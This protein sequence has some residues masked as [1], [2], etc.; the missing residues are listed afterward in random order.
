[1]GY[2]WAADY[3]RTYLMPPALDDWIGP[4]HPARFVR[5]FVERF[6][7]KEWQI[8]ERRGGFGRPAYEEELL[9]KLWMYAY[10]R[11]I[12]SSRGVERA[13][14]EMVPFMWLAGEHR[15]DHNTLWRFWTGHQRTIGRVFELGLDVSREMELVGLELQAVDGTKIQACG[16]PR[17]MTTREQLERRRER[18]HQRRLE[19]ERAI[20]QAEEREKNEPEVGGLTEELQNRKRLEEKIDELLEKI[21]PKARQNP[22]EKDARPLK[23]CG[24]GYNAQAMVDDTAGLIVAEAVVSDANDQKQLVPMVDQVVERFGQPAAETLAD[25]GYNTERALAEAEEKNYEVLVAAGPG[26]PTRDDQKPYHSTRFTHDPIRDVVV[27]PA[28]K[29]LT[30]ERTKRRKNGTEVRIFRGRECRDCPVRAACTRD[31][32]GRSFDLSPHRGAVMRQR[33]KRG[34]PTNRQRYKR[35][36]PLAERTFAVIKRQLRFTRFKARG[37]ANA[38]LEWNFICGI[39]NLKLLAALPLPA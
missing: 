10:L 27:C 6:S 17:S 26:E 35:R 38:A 34:L 32:R 7:S 23:G 16:S 4:D 15:P 28:G 18:N 21:D 8:E 2:D 12:F 33:D 37:L 24:L 14:R 36:M 30:F 29:D 1:M 11:G 25:G 3:G 39:F 9:L 31:P 20:Q 19:I 22:F 13:C 5:S